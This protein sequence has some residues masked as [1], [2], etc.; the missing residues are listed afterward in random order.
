MEKLNWD[1]MNK[2]AMGKEKCRPMDV[3]D[4]ESAAEPGAEPEGEDKKPEGT[5]TA[6]DSSDVIVQSDLGSVLA[7]FSFVCEAGHLF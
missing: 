6:E 1:E 7:N 5:S 4:E 2:C 3:D